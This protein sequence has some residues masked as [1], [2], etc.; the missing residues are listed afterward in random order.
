VNTGRPEPGAN[1]GTDN[2]VNRLA[3]EVMAGSG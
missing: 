1:L 2:A 3:E